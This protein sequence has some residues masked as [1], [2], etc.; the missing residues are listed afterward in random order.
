MGRSDLVLGGMLLGVA[1]WA[2]ENVTSDEPRYSALF[3]GAHVPF[4]PVYAFGGGAFLALSPRLRDLPWYARA[5]AYAAVGSAVEYAGCV[6]DR[7]ALG[8]CS[9]DYS[10][11]ACSRPGAGCVDFE[12]AALWGMLGLLVER[13]QSEETTWRGPRSTT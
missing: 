5:A 11:N 10:G 7:R 9:W 2:A 6:I 4:L 13:L 1:G 3:K 12:H 8:A